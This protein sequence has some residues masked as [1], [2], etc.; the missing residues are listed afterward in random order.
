MPDDPTTRPPG[1]AALDLSRTTLRG[2]RDGR[3]LR[4]PAAVFGDDS[5]HLAFGDEAVRRG[6][7]DPAGLE[8]AL[9][10]WVDDEHLALSTRLHRVGDLLTG[11]L[12]HALVALRGVGVGA[13]GEPLDLLVL[14]VPGHWGGPRRGVVE[15]CAAELRAAGLARD[16][17]IVSSTAA[18]L[19]G[20]V[21]DRPGLDLRKVVVV[22]GEA[23]RLQ[24][25]V[26]AEPERL[27]RSGGGPEQPMTLREARDEDLEP[28]AV[29]DLVVQ[30]SGPGLPASTVLIAPRG[31]REAGAEL[32]H[33]APDHVRILDGD[34]ALRGAM[35]IARTLSTRH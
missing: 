30:A 21:A 26:V 25:C 9:P 22:E 10:V 4:M 2:Y 24:A 11:L 15:R 5:G 13:H 23:D 28:A 18:I 27:L 7:A 6:L 34:C 16:I 14:A 20:A 32:W 29:W 12:S 31:G 33:G 35:E 19:A 8:A 17:E 3:A 1:R